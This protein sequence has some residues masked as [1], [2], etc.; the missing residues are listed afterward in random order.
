MFGDCEYVS[1]VGY[2]GPDSF[3]YTISDGNGG[4]DTAAVSIT[5]TTNTPPT[6]VDDEL[7]ATSGNPISHFVLGNDV[8]PDEPEGD[9]LTLTAPT[10]DVETDTAHGTVTCA[11]YGECEYTSDAGYRG[12][13]RLRLRDH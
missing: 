1:N 3:N 4:T 5:V 10:P 7:Q 2:G 9:F 11:D 8:D 6:A 13:G 12:R